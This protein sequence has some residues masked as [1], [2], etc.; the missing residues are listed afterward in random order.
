MFDLPIL[1]RSGDATLQLEAPGLSNLQ[2]IDPQLA[3]PMPAPGAP[4]QGTITLTAE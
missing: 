3:P 2:G 4:V 1:S